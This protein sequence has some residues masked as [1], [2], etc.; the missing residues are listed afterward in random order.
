MSATFTT[1]ERKHADR[2]AQHVDKLL[3]LNYNMR[4]IVTFKLLWPEQP[5]W[6]VDMVSFHPSACRHVNEPAAIDRGC[7][8]F[9]VPRCRG[10]MLSCSACGSDSHFAFYGCPVTAAILDSMRMTRSNDEK[11]LMIFAK[12]SLDDAFQGK[13]TQQQQRGRVMTV[14]QERSV[15][16]AWAYAMAANERGCRNRTERCLRHKYDL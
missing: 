9:H 15:R 8:C 5:W 14:L 6:M 11:L 13:S 12:Y 7:Q 4:D 16:N 3:R 2:L 10:A 1:D